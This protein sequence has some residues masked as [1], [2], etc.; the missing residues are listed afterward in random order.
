MKDSRMVGVVLKP[1][2]LYTKHWLPDEGVYELHPLVGDR[3]WEA[4]HHTL[5]TE[6][7]LRFGDFFRALELLDTRVLQALGRRAHCDVMAF[8]REAQEEP[9]EPTKSDGLEIVELVLERRVTLWEPGKRKKLGH[10]EEYVDFGAKGHIFEEGHDPFYGNIGVSFTPMYQLVLLPLH[11]NEE[12][13]I[14][15]CSDDAREAIGTY[16]Q[17]FTLD[18][19]V[20][21]VLWEISFYGGPEA[22]Q[23]V[24]EKLTADIT[25]IR[26]GRATLTPF[27]D[28]KKEMGW[29]FEETPDS[30]ND[31]E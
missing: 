8:L 22:R 12:V 24:K 25:D 5:E 16:K 26:E 23:E 14:W 6:G 27:E 1:D 7:D 18:E 9:S 3:Y 29:D 21:A 28:I 20:H 13:E 15:R 10:K 30:G 17:A 19:V 4:C 11:V 31:D 2:G